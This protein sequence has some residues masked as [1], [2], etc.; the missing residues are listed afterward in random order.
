MHTLRTL[1]ERI[2]RLERAQSAKHDG[3]VTLG[4][5]HGDAEAITRRV[6]DRLGLTLKQLQHGG[7]SRPLSEARWLTAAALAQAGVPQSA[8]ARALLWGTPSTVG[9]ALRSHKRSLKDRNG[10]AKAWAKISP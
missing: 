5:L 2:E 9:H 3:I 10:Y 1:A 6:C 8:I 7:K 4:H